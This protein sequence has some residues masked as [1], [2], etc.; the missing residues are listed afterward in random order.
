[1][2][3]VGH[4][5]TKKFSIEQSSTTYQPTPAPRGKK[6][7]ARLREQL[8]GPDFVMAAIICLPPAGQDAA[9][10]VDNAD[11]I[12]KD[13]DKPKPTPIGQITLRG[14]PASF[15]HHRHCKQFYPPS[16]LKD[17]RLLTIRRRIR[18]QHPT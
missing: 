2:F 5:H 11:E 13:K 9:T 16:T 10:T 6:N 3:Q 4:S 7:A 17:R 8:Q 15:Q 12:S 18:H 14:G 1:M